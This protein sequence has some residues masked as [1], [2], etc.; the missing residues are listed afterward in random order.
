MTLD[1]F[2]Y[3]TLTFDGMGNPLQ[4]RDSPPPAPLHLERGSSLH[5]CRPSVLG[6]SAPQPDQHRPSC[7]RRFYRYCGWPEEAQTDPKDLSCRRQ[8]ATAATDEKAAATNNSPAARAPKRMPRAPTQIKS[9]NDVSLRT[10]SS[11]WKKD[12]GS[13]RLAIALC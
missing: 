5:T 6:T 2:L 11:A 10:M 9:A 8:T 1:C 13:P 4:D 7:P 3:T 12:C